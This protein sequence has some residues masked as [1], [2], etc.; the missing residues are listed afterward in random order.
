MEIINNPVGHDTYL[1]PADEDLCGSGPAEFFLKEMESGKK[2]FS[3]DGLPCFVKE[4]LNTRES[5]RSIG[6]KKVTK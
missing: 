6:M 4:A 2:Q 1:F 5:V 3:R